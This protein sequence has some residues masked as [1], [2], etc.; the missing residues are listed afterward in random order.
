MNFSSQIELKA[1]A[2]TRTPPRS[3]NDERPGPPATQ[4]LSAVLI[5]TTVP[6]LETPSNAQGVGG[7][8]RRGTP[9]GQ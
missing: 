9:Q 4:T 3:V 6:S 8:A 1:E 5:Q 2:K 7:E